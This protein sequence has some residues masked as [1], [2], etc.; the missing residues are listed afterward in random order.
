MSRVG[1]FME[2]GET[3]EK[4]DRRERMRR[5]R[6]RGGR[7]G[8]RCSYPART[9]FSCFQSRQCSSSSSCRSPAF[10]SGVGE[11]PEE[12]LM[13]RLSR[14]LRNNLKKSRW[15]HFSALYQKC[16]VTGDLCFGKTFTGGLDSPAI[17]RRL[18]SCHSKPGWAASLLP[19]RKWCKD[20]TWSLRWGES[21]RSL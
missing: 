13:P 3:C 17:P 2:V 7:R 6:G 18:C 10:R 14:H 16:C 1:D 11:E 15:A 9:H 19:P 20:P 5:E 8:D 21:E 12:E 4:N